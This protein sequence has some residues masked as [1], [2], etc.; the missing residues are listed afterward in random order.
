MQSDRYSCYILTKFEFSQ[1][2]FETCSNIKY[3][4]N[5]TSG[6]RVVPSNRTD[7]QTWRS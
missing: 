3:Q 5:P 7:G 1:H 6:R 4:E 2:I